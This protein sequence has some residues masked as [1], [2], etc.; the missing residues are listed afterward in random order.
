MA[1][2]ASLVAAVVSGV[3]SH[4]L[5]SR[6]RSR[7]R[8]NP[9]MLAW[10]IA[11]ALF[12]I[13]SVALTVGAQFGFSPPLFR[14]FYLFGAVL[15]V[16]WL[17]LGSVLVNSRDRMTSRLTGVAT[18]LTALAFYASAL[19]FDP[20]A[21]VGA[22]FGTIWAVLLLDGDRDR[23]R[24]GS[25]CLVAA[26]TAVAVVTVLP[27]P[28]TAALPATGLPEGSEVLPAHVRGFAVGGNAIGSIIVIVGAIIAV[29]R[30]L[31]QFADRAD[32]DAVAETSRRRPVDALAAGILS[33]W[34]ALGPAGM[35]NL[36]TGNLFI[37]LGVAIAAGSGGMFS[38][39]GDTTAHAVGIAVGVIVMQRGFD[40]TTR[41]RTPVVDPTAV[42]VT[43][44]I[45]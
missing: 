16:A 11:L 19:E 36:A 32:R 3:F 1:L 39:L 20:L 14:I 26:F 15:N 34:R 29:G 24:V 42:P 12:C 6:W 4:Q 21:V 30:L 17:A 33:G 38:F 23:L 27:A 44:V 7:G 37:A 28:F 41:P 35:R 5:G 31:W 13:A 43:R 22:V 45:E 8:A 25:A 40:R 2:A 9:A 10:S 18:L